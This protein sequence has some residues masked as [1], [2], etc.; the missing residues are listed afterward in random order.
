MKIELNKAASLAELKRAPKQLVAGLVIMLVSSVA[1]GVILNTQNKTETLLV[2]NRDVAAGDS[3]SP[4]YFDSREVLVSALNSQW[5][6][7]DQIHG[8]TFFAISLSKGD[9]LRAADVSEISSN[10]RL[11]SFAVEE[12]ELPD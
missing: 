3:L 6:T 4:E 11:I 9:A 2:L 5:L 8:G 10:L 7:P 1:G 12:T